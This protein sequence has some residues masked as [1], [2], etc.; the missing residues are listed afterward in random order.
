MTK[1]E[2][3]KTLL[4]LCGMTAASIGINGNTPGVFYTVVSTSLHIAR[5]TFAMHA[6]LSMLAWALGSLIVPDLM[7]RISYRLLCV[8]CLVGM[9]VSTILMGCVSQVVWFYLL[10][11]LRGA[12]ASL[13]ANVPVTI[14]I[15][16]KWH[17]RT[18]T[19]TSF[20]LA[21]S[22]IAG[23]ICSPLLAQCITA[24]GWRNAYFLQAAI[25][26]ICLLPSVIMGISY[27]AE[28]VQKK[29]SQT[30]SHRDIHTMISL[31]FILLAVFSLLHT[32]LTGI[33]QHLSGMGEASGMTLE[34]GALL[35]TCAMAGNILSK[36][37]IGILS[38][39]RDAIHACT[40]MILI[41]IASLFILT[42]GMKLA[43]FPLSAI[44][45]FLFG[46]VYSVGAVGISL[47][48]RQLFP[49]TAYS[50]LYPKFAFMV[51]AGSAM[52]LPLIGYFYDFTQSYLP[53]LYIA[54]FIDA[55]DLASLALQNHALKEKVIRTVQL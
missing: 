11:I 29:T 18:G 51:S 45:A 7:K 12:A 21:F 36:L 9:C 31:S 26:A 40:I 41:N 34:Q 22:G 13:C 4:I 53:A 30:K 20:V 32:S 23:A 37:I 55:I 43:S 19:I 47:L 52:S 6:S 3:A 39:R 24:Y 2:T 5:G 33:C 42:A 38:D 50:I 14:L 54:I 17:K 15:A 10:G 25:I 28:Q 48:T 49:P 44:G 1:Q 16:Q 35:L 46:S 8:V 27:E